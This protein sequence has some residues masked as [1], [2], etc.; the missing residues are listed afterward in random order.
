MCYIVVVDERYNREEPS[1]PSGQ[2]KY[3][4]GI[5]IGEQMTAVGIR[6]QPY[7]RSFV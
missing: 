2:R 5:G 3:A 4:A 6:D 1:S 7:D